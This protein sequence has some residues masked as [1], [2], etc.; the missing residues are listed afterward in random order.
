MA[1]VTY[2]SC[3]SPRATS[4]SHGFTRLGGCPYS[5]VTSSADARS[6]LR[7]LVGAM[8]RARTTARAVH[9]REPLAGLTASSTPGGHLSA[10]ACHPC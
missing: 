6:R 10:D 9:A 3:T 7:C 8:M 2:A 4:P 1:A 5:R